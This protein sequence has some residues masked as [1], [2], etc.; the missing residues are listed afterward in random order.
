MLALPHAVNNTGMRA[1]IPL[2]TVYTISSMWTIHLL[3]SLYVD[4]K[5]RKVHLDAFCTF[6]LRLNPP[7]RL[8]EE[9]R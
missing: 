3:T 7:Q 2:I 8:L 6:F 1:A 5:A 4:L 9:P